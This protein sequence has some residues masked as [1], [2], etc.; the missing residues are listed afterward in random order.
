MTRLKFI[1]LC[2]AFTA[3][4]NAATYTA[5]TL[6]GHYQ[7][8]THGCGQYNAYTGAFTYVEAEPYLSLPPPRVAPP[9]KPKH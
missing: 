7:A 5:T 6:N 3:A 4:T 2:V 9:H 1:V 8:I